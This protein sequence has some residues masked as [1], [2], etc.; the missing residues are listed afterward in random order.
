MMTDWIIH[1]IA[2]MIG[3]KWCNLGNKYLNCR[4]HVGIIWISAVN[5]SKP[6]VKN[7]Y[8][9][10]ARATFHIIQVQH[11]RF[12]GKKVLHLNLEESSLGLGD[13]G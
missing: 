10:K 11:K 8:G 12:C 2:T 4:D 7:T 13:F 1:Q 6:L 5:A 3:V 9:R